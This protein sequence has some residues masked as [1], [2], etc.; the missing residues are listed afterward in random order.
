MSDRPDDRPL[1]GRIAKRMVDERET[2]AQRWLDRIA[3]RVSLDPQRIFPSDELLDHIPLLIDGVAAHLED[4]ACEIGADTPVLAKAME[5]G[6][7]R[8]DQGFDAYEI[9]KE[10]EILGAI[11]YSFVER[12]LREL[13]VPATHQDVFDCAR[14]LFRAV[15]MIQQRTTSRFV[16][17]AQAKVR[18]REER[19]R[20]FNRALSHEMK[21][22]IAAILGAA[23]LLAT[24]P[25]LDTEQRIRFA[26]MVTRNAREMQ[27][28]LDNLLDL[29]RLDHDARQQRHIQLA[30]AAAEVARQLRDAAEA[31]GVELRVGPMPP[32]EVNAAAVELALTNYVSNAIKYCDPQK[33]ERRVEITA[34][35]EPD[36][37]QQS[38]ALVVRVIDNGLG[39]PPEAR[40]QLFQRFFRAHEETAPSVDGSGL[41][42]NIVRETVE[43][44][45]GRAWAEFPG[46]GSVFAFAVPRRRTSEL[47]SELPTEVG[48]G[49]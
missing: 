45:G 48:T 41:G 14:R 32:V 8:H 9:L 19:L 18:E 39:V 3:A 36:A 22:R 11:L 5:L 38:A 28:T 46:E 47:E 7:L 26:R 24:V 43:S 21:N 23:E 40:A 37:D 31:H 12:E 30:R 2:L 35:I 17:R 20:A 15:S 4:P 29:S 44:L 33:P 16:E 1:A 34:T 25:E 49:G 27:T 42:L 13:P 6:D 10:Y